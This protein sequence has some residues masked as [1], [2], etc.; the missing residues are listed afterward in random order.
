MTKKEQ[1]ITMDSKTVRT[2]LCSAQENEFLIPEYQRQYSWTEEEVVILFE[3]LWNFYLSKKNENNDNKINKNETYFLGSIVFFENDNYQNE[4]IDGQQRITSL[5]LLLRAIYKLI[6]N[7]EGTSK[8]MESL[9]RD[10]ESCIWRITNKYN[11]DVDKNDILLKNDSI[12]D[13]KRSLFIEIMRDGVAKKDAKDNYS[14]NYNKLL[15][16]VSEKSKN[17]FFGLFDFSVA[18]L[19]KTT[20]LAISTG[21]Q[22]SALTIFSTLNNRGIPLSDSDIIKSKIYN[23]L[24][25]DKEKEEFVNE[26]REIE[27]K[28]EK[29]KIDKLKMNNIFYYYMFYLR[30]EV[31]DEAS[32][33]P[34]L[35]KYIERYIDGKL[36]YKTF[37]LKELLEKL[38]DIVDFL[39]FINNLKDN[40]L[41]NISLE[42]KKQLDILTEYPNDFGLYPA[43]VYYL[44]NIEKIKNGDSEEFALL[45]KKLLNKLISRYLFYPA[46]NDVKPGILLLN[47]SIIKN[48]NNNKNDFDF[49]KFKNNQEDISDKL[50]IPNIKILKMILKL[51]EYNEV[52]PNDE[53]EEELV[54]LNANIEHIRPQ[55]AVSKFGEDKEVIEEIGNKVLLEKKLNI[56]ATDDKFE[57]KKEKSYKKSKIKTAFNLTKINNE[58]W[59][60][61]DIKNRTNELIKKIKEILNN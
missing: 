13:N 1:K 5:Y 24:S 60:K 27:Q 47:K 49:S 18:I 61:N 52:K 37:V 4:I 10:I 32:T 20:I 56:R 57:F 41:H 50:V 9:K 59:E 40:N 39:E 11:A 3:D 29:T 25:S 58:S 8:G 43:V 2:L 45:I 34:G 31:G 30:A 21:S 15:E 28:V 35:K 7:S 12:N 42:T 33:T 23:K 19:E 55:K 14:K 17:E 44:K 6:E 26:W 36:E 22:E 51:L 46:V 16:L 38:N 48:A 54:D 53:W